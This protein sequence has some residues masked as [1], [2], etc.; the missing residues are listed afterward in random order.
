[1][2]IEAAAIKALAQHLPTLG[3][4][5]DTAIIPSSQPITL[6]LAFPANIPITGPTPDFGVVGSTGSEWVF[7]IYSW[8]LSST[9]PKNGDLV[10]GSVPD[11]VLSWIGWPRLHLFVVACGADGKTYTGTANALVSVRVPSIVLAATITVFFYV[12]GAFTISIPAGR[13]KGLSPLW[14]S[15]EGSGRASL[16][17]LQIIFFSVIVLYLVAY[18]LL[19]TGILANLSNSVLLLLGIAGVGSVGGKLATRNS[20]RLSFDNWA[21]V[22]RKGWTTATGYQVSRPQWSDLFTTNG[23]FDPYKFQMLS[24]SFLIG[25]SL[26]TTGL[27]GLVANFTVPTALLAVIGVSQATYIGGMKFGPMAQEA[28]LAFGYLDKKLTELRKAQEDFLTATADTWV[29]LTAAGTA[30]RAAQL[31]AARTDNSAKYIKFELLVGDAYTMF[32]ELF[33]A[34]GA[35]PNLEP[36]P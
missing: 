32:A 31:A 11:R 2:P 4:T 14:L 33:V 25:V 13:R 20:Q 8:K 34:R 15:I 12:C 3:V 9:D 22:K 30:Q 26:L 16:S 21:W 5:P 6:H 17:N 7:P 36:D 10:V 27:S 24:F 19:R 28:A 1:M 35:T 29:P 18:I 23:N